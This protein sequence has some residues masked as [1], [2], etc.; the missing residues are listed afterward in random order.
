[1]NILKNWRLTVIL[2]AVVPLAFFLSNNHSY[3]S[4]AANLFSLC[5]MTGLGCLAALACDGLLRLLA[6]SRPRTKT[7]DDKGT[8]PAG[9]DILLV[10]LAVLAVFPFFLAHPWGKA[11]PG[12]ALAL[13][14]A[15]LFALF[16]LTGFALANV[17]LATSLVLSSATLFWMESRG[18]EEEAT[19]SERLMPAPTAL[20]R[21]FDLA[22]KPNI[23][24][25]FL[26]SFHDRKTIVSEY[27]FDAP[28][29]FADMERQGFT[30]Y[31]GYYANYPGT[32][33][34]ALALFSMRHHYNAFSKN[35]EDIHR[36]GVVV[37]ADN[38]VFAVLKHNGYGVN[39]LDMNGNYVFRKRSRQVDFKHFHSQ[40]D[41]LFAARN[42]T[43]RVNPFLQHVW[44]AVLPLLATDV[45]YES[46]TPAEIF[47]RRYPEGFGLDGRPQFFY[48]HFGA[49]HLQKSDRS[50]H[51]AESEANWPDYYRKR[52]LKAAEELTACLDAI[53]ERDPDGLVI[54]VGDHG[55]WKY[56]RYAGIRDEDFRDGGRRLNAMLR[57]EGVEPAGVAKHLVG[58]LASVRWPRGMAAP[59]R[60]RDGLSHVTLFPFVFTALA[61]EGYDSSRFARNA[62]FSNYRVDALC[63]LLAMDG[64]YLADWK[65]VIPD[66]EN[67]GA[68]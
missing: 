17:F 6:R 9:V 40:D 19:P 58:V 48:L 53:R 67:W 46:G 39:L 30:D 45:A 12:V 24:L 61:G 29:L 16:R 1:M 36:A 43:V 47:L 37:L 27:G 55:A 13:A 31:P 35:G 8:K 54:L 51:S 7:P 33:D 28:G 5:L 64:E 41:I 14:L 32:L 23:Y 50:F 18:R 56:G 57:K 38:N 10:S 25:F 2:A 3:W 65:P 21:D 26:E 42:A 63:M 68:P 15:G 62:A 60:P 59:A 4:F 34:A 22:R 66:E 52:Y 49:V 20:P 11:F 44:R